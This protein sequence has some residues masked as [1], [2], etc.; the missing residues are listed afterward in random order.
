MLALATDG[1]QHTRLSQP[2]KQIL[3]K[4]QDVVLHYPLSNT[5]TASSEYGPASAGM[6]LDSQDKRQDD[7]A[8]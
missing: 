4:T 5:A 3:E 1:Q 2:D 7:G 8:D 6:T